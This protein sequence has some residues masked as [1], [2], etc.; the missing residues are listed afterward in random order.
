MLSFGQYSFSL[1]TK[2]AWKDEADSPDDQ[3]IE[4]SNLPGTLL[5]LQLWTLQDGSSVFRIKPLAGC[6]I[7]DLIGQSRVNE[8]TMMYFASERKIIV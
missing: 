7:L 8:K 3:L 2:F 1:K 5:S 6:N 4:E